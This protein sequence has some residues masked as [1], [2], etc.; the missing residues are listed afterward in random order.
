[1]EIAFAPRKDVSGPTLVV[2]ARGIDPE[3]HRLIGA[4]FKRK[5][6]DLEQF[7]RTRAPGKDTHE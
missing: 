4:H 7:V 1:M 2:T 6:S 5:T 3:A